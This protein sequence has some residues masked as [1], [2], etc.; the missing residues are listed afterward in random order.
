[1]K[2]PFAVEVTKGGKVKRKAEGGKRIQLSKNLCAELR[3]ADYREWVWKS[4]RFFWP[5]VFETQRPRE[6]TQRR[7]K[8]RILPQSTQSIAEE[9]LKGNFQKQ[10]LC[11]SL[12][13]LR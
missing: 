1:M 8:E 12:R 3:S 5:P 10:S 2:T 4:E 6:L 7:G 11:E 13:S 9:K